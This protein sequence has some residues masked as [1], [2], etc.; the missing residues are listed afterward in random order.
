VEQPNTLTGYNLDNPNF[1]P[2]RGRIISITLSALA[3]RSTQPL[4]QGTGTLSQGTKQ[5]ESE[6]N[7]LS[8][9]KAIVEMYGEIPPFPYILMA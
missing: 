1:I 9:S 6:A 3:M 7:S 8:P 5:L 2:A 4:I